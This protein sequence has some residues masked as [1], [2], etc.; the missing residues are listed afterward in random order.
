MHLFSP[1]LFT[2]FD[3]FFLV[4]SKMTTA[5]SPSLAEYKVTTW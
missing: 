3:S 1:V 5:L 2:A 4:T